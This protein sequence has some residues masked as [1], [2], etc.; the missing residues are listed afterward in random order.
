MAP[1]GRLD[2]RQVVEFLGEQGLAGQDA[3]Q[4]EVAEVRAVGQEARGQRL[5]HDLLHG[6]DTDA[7][8]RDVRQPVRAALAQQVERV[9]DDGRVTPS[10][11]VGEQREPRRHVLRGEIEPTSE[12]LM[13][14]RGRYELVEVDDCECSTATSKANLIVFE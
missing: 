13:N 1:E 11:S 10:P 4:A 14:S 3:G 9:A 12:G 2:A 5:P 7:G 6:R 8:D